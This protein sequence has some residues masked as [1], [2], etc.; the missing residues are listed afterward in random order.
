MI[1]SFKDDYEL[2]PLK[3]LSQLRG[4]RFNEKDFDKTQVLSLKGKDLGYII[5]EQKDETVYILYIHIFDELRGRGIGRILLNKITENGKY[6][7]YGDAI[8]QSIKFWKKMN[9]EF[10]EDIEDIMEGICVPFH[11]E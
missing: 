5:S 10:D 11:K 3:N 6:G 8:P 7:F 1:N 9:V 2:K 4:G